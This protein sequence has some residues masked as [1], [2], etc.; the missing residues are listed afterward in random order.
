MGLL[1]LMIS[2]VSYAAPEASQSALSPVEPAPSLPEDVGSKQTQPEPAPVAPSEEVF[3]ALDT[4]SLLD[5]GY[6][7]PDRVIVVEGVV[8]RTFYAEASSGSPTFLDFHD[9]YQDWFT[10]VIWEED[11][12]DFCRCF[13]PDRRTTSCRRG[14]G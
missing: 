4:E 3:D 5:I 7:E 14:C 8:V 2:V 12:E 1:L 10:C 6:S 9:P 11:R 13:P